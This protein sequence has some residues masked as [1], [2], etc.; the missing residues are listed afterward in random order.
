[1]TQDQHKAYKF[2][3]R[4]HEM[5]KEKEFDQEQL[6]MVLSM[7]LGWNGFEGIAKQMAA[8][9]CDIREHDDLFLNGQSEKKQ[10]GVIS[11][12][13]LSKA[14]S[15]YTDRFW[16]MGLAKRQGRGKT[17]KLDTDG[18]AKLMFFWRDNHS[19]GIDTEAH[20]ESE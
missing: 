4:M 17:Y 20:G 10:F 1:M 14:V 2:A 15:I 18:A 12:E 9:E 13:D 11:F 8:H 5:L 7:L 16:L 6:C 19:S 3:R